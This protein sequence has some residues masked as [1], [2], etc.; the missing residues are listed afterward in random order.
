MLSLSLQTRK[1]RDDDPA[2]AAQWK[3]VPFFVEAKESYG[4]Q[5]YFCMGTHPRLVITD[6]AMVRQAYVGNS[7]VLEKNQFQRGLK[8][9]GDGLVTSN[10]ELWSRQRR[11]ISP[12]F[13]HRE[14]K[15]VQL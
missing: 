6:P 11:L 4:D 10:G 5:Y 14:M 7:S 15:V 1:K 9:L 12:A 8:V 2:L 13:N 3:G